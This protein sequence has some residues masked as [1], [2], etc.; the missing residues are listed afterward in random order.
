MN[1]YDVTGLRVEYIKPNTNLS[2]WAAQNRPRALCNGSLYDGGIQ[3]YR[4]PAGPPVGTTYE[5]GLLVRNEGNNPGMGI[6]DEKLVFGYPFATKWPYFIGGYNCPVINGIYNKPTWNDSY[7]FNTKNAR[8]GIGFTKDKT[9]ICTENNIT[10]KGFA[11]AA[12]NKGIINLVNLDGG[13]SRHLHYNGKAIYSSPRVPYNAL[14]FYS[15]N[16]EQAICPYVEPIR[17]I[18]YGSIGEGAKWVQWQLT[19]HGFTCTDDGL[20]Y[21]KSVAA[22]REF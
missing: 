21:S 22:L 3:F 19:R 16:G 6:Q 14:A 4:R 15:V 10:L 11:D 20:F 8:I 7:V 17:N 12:I 13:G 18:R 9:Y 1:L 5:N 2:V